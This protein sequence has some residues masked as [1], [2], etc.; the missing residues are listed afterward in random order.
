MMVCE[1]PPLAEP[2][3]SPG[4][5]K[6]IPPFEMGVGNLEGIK[7]QEKYGGMDKYV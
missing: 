5:G 4:G 7:K 3:K 1:A 6:T 2:E